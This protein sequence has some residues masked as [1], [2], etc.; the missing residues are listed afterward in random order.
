MNHIRAFLPA[1]IKSFLAPKGV[2]VSDGSTF[3]DCDE[4][5]ISS[6]EWTDHFAV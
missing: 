1:S 5:S 2:A 3:P 6:E 4:I